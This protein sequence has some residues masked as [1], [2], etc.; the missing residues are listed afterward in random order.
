MATEN[1]KMVGIFPTKKRALALCAED[2]V[3]TKL[4]WNGYYYSEKPLDKDPYAC[5]TITLFQP[6][7]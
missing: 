5:G 7:F 1:G 6:M 2:V 4:V 3:L